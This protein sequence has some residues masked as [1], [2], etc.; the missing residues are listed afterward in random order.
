MSGKYEINMTEG[1]IPKKMLRFTIPFVLM[2]M[3]QLTFN[4][5]DNLVVGAFA[6]S[7]ALAAVSSSGPIVNLAVNLF[8][9]LSIG[10]NM[11]LSKSIGADNKKSCEEIVHSSIALS[12]LLG[13]FFAITG[14]SLSGFLTK[15]IK[16]PPEVAPYAKTY[17]RIY[18]L[19][20]PGLIAYNFGASILRSMGDTKRPL[21]Y[22]SI[23]GVVN[24]LLNLLLVIKFDMNAGGVAIATTTSQ[25]I[26]A[27]LTLRALVKERGTCQL[28]LTRIRL[29]P[30]KCLIILKLGIP[31][32][33]QGLMF[34]ISNITIQSCL[35]GF[36][37]NAMAGAGAASTLNG[38]I[39]ATMSAMCQTALAFTAQNYGAKKY[40]RIK[41]IY[42]VS[43]AYMFA[44]FG[45]VCGIM[46][47][48][49]RQLI[50]M[51]VPNNP[52]AM[53]YGMISFRLVGI[54]YFICGIMEVNV[55]MLRGLGRSMIPTIISIAG[56][57]GV[58]L[59]WIYTAFRAVPT[60][61]CLYM[62]YPVT[63][64]I[65]STAQLI[66]L[67]IVYKKEFPKK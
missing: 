11:I 26:S 67:F 65:T 23:A 25:Y 50:G 16:M 20:M 48:L 44:M 45:I 10:T 42:P 19:G 14:F 53:E 28:V 18:F 9:G 5:A 24:V 1:S 55:G 49:S 38:Y 62:S 36:G 7:L 59:I 22:L 27:F 47:I 46:M 3:L 35:N 61:V 60:M 17:L 40:D 29:I 43:L 51:F 2:N 33:V 37:A 54:L 64:T 4:S 21:Y 58:R 32:S 56:I 39:F 52:E 30:Q 63:W 57:C 41:K 8:S 13:L 66:Y 15:L 6:G 31:A 12:L 34:S